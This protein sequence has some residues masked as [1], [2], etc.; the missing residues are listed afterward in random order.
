MILVILKAEIIY[1]SYYSQGR[2]HLSNFVRI[3]TTFKNT[4]SNN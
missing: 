1:D 4:P 2:N 3:E